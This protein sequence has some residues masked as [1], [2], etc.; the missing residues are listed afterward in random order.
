MAQMPTDF[1]AVIP[2]RYASSRLPGKPLADIGGHP[3]IEWVYRRTKQSG[4]REVLVATDDE[5]V[6]EACRAF[7]GRVEMTGAHHASGTDRIAELIERSDWSERQIIVNVQGDEPLLPPELID[8]VARL[9]QRHTDAGMATLVTAVR[10]ENEWRDPSTVKV[11]V[12][13]AGYALYF[14]RAPIPRPRDGDTVPPGAL[15]HVGLYAYRASA[16]R[17]L[18]ASPPCALEQTEG[19]EQLRALWLG[20]RIAVQE[21]C[22]EP[23]RAVDTQADLAAVRALVVDRGVSV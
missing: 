12:D 16:L 15:R 1:I 4:A 11:I 23:P 20:L 21:A 17:T 2:A 18:A 9:M 10:S 5:R 3:M 8:Q 6:A 22:A 14:S 13:R 19:L 7:A